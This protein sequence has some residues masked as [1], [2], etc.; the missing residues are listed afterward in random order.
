MKRRSRQSKSNGGEPKDKKR[1]N[2][3]R[4]RARVDG[5]K[6]KCIFKPASNIVPNL[7]IKRC[8]LCF[9]ENVDP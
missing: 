6:Q 3:V 5:S 8:S 2:A 9:F 1:F 4:R 7:N